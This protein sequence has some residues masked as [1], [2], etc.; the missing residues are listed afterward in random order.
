ME[1]GLYPLL[2]VPLTC[3]AVSHLPIV[4][5]IHKLPNVI[6]SL[7]MYIVPLL[8]AKRCIGYVDKE[9]DYCAW[10]SV[11]HIHLPQGEE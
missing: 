1:W 11:W 10:H 3:S 4:P 7:S 6:H 2:A 9:V 8:N 5:S